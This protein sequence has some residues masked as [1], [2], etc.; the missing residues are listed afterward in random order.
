MN[1]N[2]R[3]NFVPINSN[4]R[5][6]VDFANTTRLQSIL[7]ADLTYLAVTARGTTPR[8]RQADT[9]IP[10]DIGGHMT[11]SPSGTGVTYERDPTAGDEPIEAEKLQAAIRA[12]FPGE[13]GIKDMAI[14]DRTV[15]YPVP[16]ELEDEKLYEDTSFLVL[17]S[18]AQKDLARTVQHI[19]TNTIPVRRTLNYV[20]GQ[21]L[22]NGIIKQSERPYY[23][24]M[25]RSLQYPYNIFRDNEPGWLAFKDT[26]STV[27]E[28]ITTGHLA[29]DTAKRIPFRG[30]IE[31]NGLGAP[32][33]GHFYWL[34]HGQMYA[35]W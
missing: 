29:Q 28:A 13:E 17:Q 18:V 10:L 20:M 2:G 35:A 4:W 19:S 30:A 8:P 31:N 5:L 24:K 26:M 9:T 1:G 23:A 12:A 25:L 14:Q 27:S 7:N 32:W 34:T 33:T 22:D 6:P 16:P 11:I 3:K 21:L 15:A